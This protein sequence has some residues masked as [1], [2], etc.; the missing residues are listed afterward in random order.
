M[1]TRATPSTKTLL[2][3]IITKSD[4][5]K[6]SESG[7]IE[8]GISDHSMVYI[9]RKVSVPRQKP[10]IVETRQFKNFN[11]V[12]FQNDLEQV[13]RGFT[14]NYDPSIA[15]N[16]WKSIFLRVVVDIHAPCCIRKV[17][18][19]G[20]LWLN[21]NIKKLRHHRDFLKK[22]AMQLN[23]PAYHEAYKRCKN[24]VTTLIRETRASYYKRNLENCT[25][26]K[27]GWNYINELLN[28]KSQTTIINEI[29]ADEKTITGNQNIANEFNKLFCEIGPRLCE[30]IP[31]NN[32]DPLQYVTPS[33]GEF[34]FRAIYESELN[35]VLQ[36]LKL[37]KASRLDKIS[38]KLLKAAGYTINE[39][40]LFIFNLA[41]ATGIFPDE[42][43]MA[44]VTPIYKEGDKSNCGNYRPISVLPVIAKIL[45]KLICDQLR[46]FLNENN[47]SKQQS[48]FRKLY[49]TETSLLQITDKWL[50]NIDKGLINS[51]LFLD[52]K[53]AFDTVNHQIILSKLEVYGIRN[54]ALNLLKSYLDNRMQI[55][56]VEGIKSEPKK[57][58]CGV[59]QGSNL[60][61]CCFPS[62]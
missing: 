45:E 18:S 30:D 29:K 46:E 59:P 20:T 11:T 33:K 61:L 28:R 40:L 25:N 35:K 36:S 52:L 24:Q 38:N 7:V 44:K 53:K 4:D 5:T 39:S 47:I 56:V 8:L 3:I 21:E 34:S 12:Q 60:G 43:K 2:D 57:V 37:S 23:S 55:C 42:L 10:K 16:K 50:M 31:P 58:I 15:W 6:I 14:Y 26:N 22:K 41:L 27:D 49:S 17:K 54:Q 32:D 13:L 1:P 48:G 62:T 51:V 19:E 9:C